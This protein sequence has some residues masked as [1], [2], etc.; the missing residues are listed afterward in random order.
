MPTATAARSY[1][2]VLGVHRGAK[3]AYLRRRYVTLTQ[4]VHPDRFP[5]PVERARKAEVFKL[6]N[7]AWEVLSN[8]EQRTRY[9]SSL[10]GG[11]EFQ[12]EAGA[13][14]TAASIFG[15]AKRF[16]F[17]CLTALPDSLKQLVNDQLKGVKE[18][19]HR[20]VA[21]FPVISSNVGKSALTAPCG[22]QYTTQ[23]VLTNMN[24]SVGIVGTSQTQSGNTTYT[25]TYTRVAPLYLGAIERLD[26]SLSFG[27]QEDV[28][29]VRI[30]APESAFSGTEFTCRGSPF[31]FL[32]LAD[33]FDIRTLL[34]LTV[35]NPPRPGTPLAVSAVAVALCLW[36]AVAGGGSL[37]T[38]GSLAVAGIYILQGFV[39]SARIAGVRRLV[40]YGQRLA[41][42]LAHAQH[43]R[44]DGAPP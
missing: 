36:M 11:T 27:G 30:N 12:H 32:W 5:D 31:V 26:I 21:T 16:E 15:D 35:T 41:G 8:P 19:E 43:D 40:E 6:I 34:G 28:F 17:N 24:L 23:L 39:E 29:T 33:L 25:M 1:Y 37:Q 3:L 10:D 18:F 42:R 4:E 44:E 2:D 9:D 38:W 14:K 7:E 13:G 22:A 20:V